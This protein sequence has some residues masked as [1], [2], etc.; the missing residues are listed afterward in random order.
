MN[1]DDLISSIRKEAVPIDGT[2]H[3]PDDI[4]TLVA[5]A[6]FVLIGEAS[7][8]THE[9]YKYRAE[10]T[11]RLIREKGFSAIAVEADFPDAYRVNRYIRGAG[12]DT[13]AEASL[14]DFQRFPLWM[15]RN[16]DVL[17]LVGWL[18][19]HNDAT[20]PARRVGF[21]GIDLYSMHSSM[22]AVLNYL[23]RID[24]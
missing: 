4:L 11:K 24:P 5:D 6:K 18:R 13:S 3:V 7:H 21:Y 19:E 22:Q 10:L 12:N 17:D 14:E 20:A 23:D 9:F 15:W 2:G 1:N 8:G 16:A